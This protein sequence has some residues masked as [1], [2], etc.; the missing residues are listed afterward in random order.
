[1]PK[2]VCCSEDTVITLDTGTGEVDFHIRERKDYCFNIGDDLARCAKQWPQTDR[3]GIYKD[4]IKKLS[5]DLITA[6]GI[7]RTT[8][9]EVENNRAIYKLAE[10]CRDV[11]RAILKN[12]KENNL[13]L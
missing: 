2:L 8:A 9:S 6:M 7:V 4:T 1:M 5:T 12:R 10:E 11:L 3:E 13:G